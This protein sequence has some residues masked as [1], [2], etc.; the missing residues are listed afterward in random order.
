MTKL[1]LNR[2]QDGI[3]KI[4]SASVKTVFEYL[5]F[6][7]YVRSQS[8]SEKRLFAAEYPSICPHVYYFRTLYFVFSSSLASHV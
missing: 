3:N 6:F 4:L 7:Y 2:M 1:F 8:S 5:I